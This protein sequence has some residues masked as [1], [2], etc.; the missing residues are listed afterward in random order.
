MPADVTVVGRLER[1]LPPEETYKLVDFSSFDQTA[2]VDKLL[3][4]LAALSPMIGQRVI[5][6]TD[7]QARHP[8]VFVTPVAMYR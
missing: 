7:L 6:E 4:A 1:I 2:G 3:Q 5:T 8:D